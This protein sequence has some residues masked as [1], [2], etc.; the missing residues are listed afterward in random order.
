MAERM[1]FFQMGTTPI[2]L[3]PRH[4]LS[5]EPLPPDELGHKSRIRTTKHGTHYIVD[6]KASENAKRVEGVSD[7]AG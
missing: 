5:I 7:A 3:N 1:I 4:I 6:G 2:Y